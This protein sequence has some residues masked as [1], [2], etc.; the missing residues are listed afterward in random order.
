LPSDKNVD[1]LEE[2]K[3]KL[4]SNSVLI[5]TGFTGLDVATMTKFRRKLREQGLEY[6]VVKNTIASLAA[7]E[8]GFPQIKEVL[9]GPTGLVM[10]NGD[11]IAAA[12][13]LTEYLRSSRIAMPLNGAVIDGQVMTAQEVNELGALPTKP[14]LMSMLMGQLSGVVARLMRALNS[15]AQGLAV[16]LERSTENKGEA[17]VDSTEEAPAEASTDIPPAADAA[18]DTAEATP[19][20]TP[21]ADN[22]ADE[23]QAEETPEEEE[24]SEESAPEAERAEEEAP[25][26]DTA[27]EVEPDTEESDDA[28]ETDKTDN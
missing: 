19:A 28:P 7:D 14:V 18:A 24:T 12:K 4:A 11:A 8:I 9:T 17:N 2:I 27:A 6:R 1:A 10:G 16:V 15:P 3:E 22:A 13:L 21:E 5:S 26:D 23:A 25:A 20:D